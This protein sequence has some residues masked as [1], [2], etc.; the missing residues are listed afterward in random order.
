MQIDSRRSISYKYYLSYMYPKNIVCQQ[1]LL[2]T[3]DYI[4]QRFLIYNIEKCFLAKSEKNNACK[5]TI[6]K[7]L[8]DN[9]TIFKVNRF[10]KKLPTLWSRY[11]SASS[12][13]TYLPAC[14]Q[15][16]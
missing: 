16:L 15:R 1:L 5:K 9:P 8:F 2:T 4:T 12:N 6:S 3:L 10:I 13:K 7:N 11:C 14:Q